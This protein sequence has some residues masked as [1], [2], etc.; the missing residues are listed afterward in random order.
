MPDFGRL[1]G[2]FKA[3]VDALTARVDY[4]A[5][6]PC[7]VVGQS[8]NELELLPDDAKMRGFGVGAVAIKTGAPGYEYDVPDG[9][10]VL[11]GFEAGDPSRPYCAL[12]QSETDVDTITFD[13]GSEDIARTSDSV[14][15]GY[16]VFETD[17][18]A[19]MYLP[20]PPVYFPGGTVG[21]VAATAYK[22]LLDDPVSS[23][24]KL[25]VLVSI[26]QGVITSGNTKLKA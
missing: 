16:L 15:A 24:G 4:H 2:A 26:N 5:L 20:T 3:A 19:T 8:G 6:Y 14:D 21:Q 9:A 22:A 18:P 25:G 1:I 17:D 11:L 13:G 10:R 7:T 12:W 23:P